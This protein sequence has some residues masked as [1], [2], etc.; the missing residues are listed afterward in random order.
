MVVKGAN[1]APL[2][3]SADSDTLRLMKSAGLHRRNERG[4]RKSALAASFVVTFAAQGAAGC[5][6][7]PAEQQ[8]DVIEAGRRKEP[9]RSIYRDPFGECRLAHEVSCPV[10]ATC[11]PPP[12]LLIDCPPD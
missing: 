8:V 1:R 12:P 4:S 9:S 6:K 7:Q 5:K 11:N 3:H 2:S 10:G